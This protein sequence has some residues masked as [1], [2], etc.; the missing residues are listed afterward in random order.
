MTLQT[1]R[2]TGDSVLITALPPEEAVESLAARLRPFIL[3]DDPIYH[4]KV[5]NALK[6]LLSDPPC[7]DLLAEVG[8]L[9]VTWR[10][11]DSRSDNMVGYQVQTGT[12][13]SSQ[14]DRQASDNTLAFSWF[15]GDVIHADQNRRSA[16]DGFDID[17]RYEAAA[18]LAARIAVCALNTLGLVGLARSRG[19]IEL[20]EEAFTDE[21]VAS[22]TQIR[23]PV[24]VW[25]GDPGAPP[26]ES[27]SAPFGAGWSRL[28]PDSDTW[29]S[30]LGD[31]DP[32]QN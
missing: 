29:R 19:A 4:A 32:P 18:Y 10:A 17:T 6:D 21:V 16:A 3:K 1:D 28:A 7:G 5:L 22:N 31:A 25:F 13:D 23:R 9:R 12:I 15:Y 8:K 27:L 30:L 11:F 2:D 14:P 24:S 20:D 26:P